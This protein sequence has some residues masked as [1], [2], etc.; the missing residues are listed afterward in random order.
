MVSFVQARAN[1]VDR[2]FERMGEAAT[3]SG[4]SGFVQVILREGDEVAGT[5]DP[6]FVLSTH[7]VRVRRSEVAAPAGGDTVQP[8]ESGGTYLIVGAPRI[9]RKGVWICE[10]VEA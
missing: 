7:F 9:D 5:D 8:G 2:I 4:I 3:W 1:A 10:A 6:G